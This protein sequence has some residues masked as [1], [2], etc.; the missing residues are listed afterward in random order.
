AGDALLT[1]QRSWAA[2]FQDHRVDDVATESRHTPP[3]SLVARTMSCD[4]RELCGELT[5]HRRLQA[6]GI[7]HL[8]TQRGVSTSFHAPRW[9]QRCG[10]AREAYPAGEAQQAGSGS[11]APRAPARAARI[12]RRGLRP[13]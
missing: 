5:H 9:L 12:R 1:G 3:P 4:I 6:P 11:R 8:W 10:M 2:A 7:T 13:G